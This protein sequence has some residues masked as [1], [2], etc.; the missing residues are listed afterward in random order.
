MCRDVR[1]ED[2]ESRHGNSDEEDDEEDEAVLYVR[3]CGCVSSAALVSA[4]TAFD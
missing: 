4:M 3:S 2:V 1:E